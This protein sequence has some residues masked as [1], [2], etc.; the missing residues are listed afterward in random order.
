VWSVARLPD[1]EHRNADLVVNGVELACEIPLDHEPEP[2]GP[3]PFG[4]L[5][6]SLS[7][8]TAMSVRDFL[9][10]WRVE[11]GEVTVRV[12]VRPGPQP[13]M[14]RRVTVGAVVGTDLRGQLADCVDNTPVTRVLRDN[15][16]IRTT[17]I[18]G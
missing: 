14:D 18:T 10:R 15:I 8:C 13:M 2:V 17:L 3:T 12:A 9:Q 6:G 7:A 4:L 1:T 11:P 16:T 5:A